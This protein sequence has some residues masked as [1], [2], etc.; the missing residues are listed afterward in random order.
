MIK[1]PTKL[2]GS[3][4]GVAESARDGVGVT[5]M[6]GIEIDGVAVRMDDGSWP[7]GLMSG[8]WAEEEIPLA[9]SL[10]EGEAASVGKRTIRGA[11][12]V[13]PT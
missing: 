10:A 1:G 13:D 9:G 3:A 11:G 12:A 6:S 4:E 8:S 7:V 5:M 2:D